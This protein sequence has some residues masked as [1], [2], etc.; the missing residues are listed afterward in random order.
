MADL[1][2]EQI[3]GSCLWGGPLPML[4]VYC[5]LHGEWLFPYGVPEA[6]ALFAAEHADCRP[7]ELDW[8]RTAPAKSRRRCCCQ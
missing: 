3:G 4:R 6:A 7:R 1:V 5:P 2:V 8:S